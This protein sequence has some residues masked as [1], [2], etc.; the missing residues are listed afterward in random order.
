MA[1]LNQVLSPGDVPEHLEVCAKP[2]VQWN[3]HRVIFVE[4][5][6]R[7][8]LRCIATSTFWA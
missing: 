8:H 7:L 2:H 1:Q 3:V 4:A 6:L 5:R